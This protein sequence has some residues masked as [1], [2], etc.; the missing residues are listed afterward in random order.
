MNGLSRRGIN[1]FFVSFFR[2]SA[3][4][5]GHG[6]VKAS[7]IKGLAAQQPPDGYTFLFDITSHSVNPVLGRPMPYKVLEIWCP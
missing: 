1:D 7:L 6:V 4:F 3:S 5:R 2:F